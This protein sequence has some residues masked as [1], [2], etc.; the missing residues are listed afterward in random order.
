MIFSISSPA[1][2][3]LTR[4]RIS[5]GTPWGMHRDGL[6][7]KTRVK[8]MKIS[9]RTGTALQTAPPPGADRHPRA[10]ARLH[11]PPYPPVIVPTLMLAAHWMDPAVYTASRSPVDGTPD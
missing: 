9:I 7:P 5:L 8:L 1:Y 6:E 4:A 3:A 10:F 2:F 11:S